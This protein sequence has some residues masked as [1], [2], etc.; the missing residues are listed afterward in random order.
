MIW[1][2]VEY[3]LVDV[4]RFGRGD[5]IVRGAP[6]HARLVE[7][8]SRDEAMATVDRPGW[9]SAFVPDFGEPI[10]MVMCPRRGRQGHDRPR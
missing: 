7:A 4:T 1:V 6:A 8:G 5:E 2:V 9:Y 10:E 3:E